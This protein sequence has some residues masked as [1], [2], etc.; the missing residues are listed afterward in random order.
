M[1]TRRLHGSSNN[2]LW[3]LMAGL[4][5]TH[6]IALAFTLKAVPCFGDLRLTGNY[7]TD[8][9]VNA[10]NRTMEWQMQDANFGNGVR[11]PLITLRLAATSHHTLLVPVCFA[12]WWC[13]EVYRGQ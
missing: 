10:L 6:M 7:I 2:T 9:G 11:P 8:A 3:H 13:Q 5:D 12:G 4:R 1:G